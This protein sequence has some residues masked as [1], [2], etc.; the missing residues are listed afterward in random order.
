VVASRAGSLRRCAIDRH[1][2][3]RRPSGSRCCLAPTTFRF[4]EGG[5]T[6]YKSTLDMTRDEFDAHSKQTGI[7]QMLILPCMDAGSKLFYRH[8][9]PDG[10]T[11]WTV[12][13]WLVLPNGAEYELTSE[14]FDRIRWS[15][16]L[17]DLVSEDESTGTKEYALNDLGASIA[18]WATPD[19]SWMDI[20]HNNPPDV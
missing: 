4:S 11:K 3:R 20:I 18:A 14:S 13:T 16:R 7:D 12:M 15:L 8:W 10:A 1:R 6:V 2:R 9:R 5:E 17:G 19:M